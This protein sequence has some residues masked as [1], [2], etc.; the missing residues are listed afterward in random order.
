M[1]EQN[2]PGLSVPAARPAWRRPG[3]Y[4]LLLRVI[5][6]SVQLQLTAES[7]G[8]VYIKSTESGQY[9]AMDSDGLL[10]GSV[11]MRPTSFQTPPSSEVC[12]NLV[13]LSDT[14]YKATISLVR[15]CFSGRIPAFYPALF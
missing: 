1:N 11:S 14:N 13:T 9:L 7:V 10:F 15:F 4:L 6:V 5:F 12:R 8:E 2:F 3:V